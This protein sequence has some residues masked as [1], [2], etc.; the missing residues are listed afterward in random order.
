LATDEIISFLRFK[1]LNEISDTIGELWSIN[2]SDLIA[3]RLYEFLKSENKAIGAKEPNGLGFEEVKIF[4]ENVLPKYGLQVEIMI[5]KDIVCEGKIDWIYCEESARDYTSWRC[6]APRDDM[7]HVAIGLYC[8]ETS[9]NEPWYF[10]LAAELE[11][12]SSNAPTFELGETSKELLEDEPSAESMELKSDA[13]PEPQRIIILEKMKR[14]LTMVFETALLSYYAFAGLEANEKTR[15]ELH[16]LEMTQQA[17]LANEINAQ[18]DGMSHHR[19]EVLC[20]ETSEHLL[21]LLPSH[22]HKYYFERNKWVM[23]CRA[24]LS[25]EKLCNEDVAFSR[26]NIEAFS[27][28]LV[29]VIESMDPEP[30]LDSFFKKGAYKLKKLITKY[31]KML[32]ETKKL[33]SKLPL[34]APTIDMMVVFESDAPTV[35]SMS[36]SDAPTVESMSVSDAPTVE[37]MS[38][39]DV[40]T[41]VFD[42]PTVVSDAPTIE[43][44]SDVS[45]V[46]T[47]PA[48]QHDIEQPIKRARHDIPATES[49]ANFMDLFLS[50]TDNPFDLPILPESTQ[51]INSFM[52]QE[53]ISSIRTDV[54]LLQDQFMS[55]VPTV[56]SMSDVPTIVVSDVPTVESMSDVP[57]IVVSDAPTVESDVPTVV[58]DAPTVVFDAPTVVSDISTV[59]SMSD[60]PTIVVSDAPTVVFDAPT[61]VS[62]IPTTVVSDAPTGD[63]RYARERIHYLMG[64]CM[65]KIYIDAAHIYTKIVGKQASEYFR[66]ELIQLELSQRAELANEINGHLDGMSGHDI[67][68]LFGSLDRKYSRLQIVLDLLLQWP[69]HFHKYYYTRNKWLMQCQANLHFEKLCGEDVSFLSSNFAT[70]S[71]DIDKEIELMVPEITASSFLKQGAP[72]LK[73]LI[74][75]YS[76]LLNPTRKSDRRSQN[77]TSELADEHEVTPKKPRATRDRGSQNTASELAEHEVTPKKSLATQKSRKSDRESQNTTSDFDEPEVTPKKPRVSNSKRIEHAPKVLVIL[78]VITFVTIFC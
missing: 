30:R 22:F 65:E 57:T 1:M 53:D 64:R 50:P 27:L 6:E 78:F 63:I 76:K 73:I 23:G 75:Q 70:F 66:D 36:V 61:V 62:D 21:L 20:S 68:A 39:S 71:E 32:K 58:S 4:V 48:V 47:V 25:F 35:E 14:C 52:S 19:M 60:V 26:C 54:N 56:E 18:L 29:Q 10:V 34:D 28:D 49:N 15:E 17:K 2:Q 33:N 44:M 11:V 3:D 31:S 16:L 9:S 46:P 74:A 43:L 51:I 55:D 38:V 42:A 69:S 5:L 12:V 7:A 72:K 13:T 24:N 37:S 77:T 45:T 41:I 59:E 8:S 40:P 67:K